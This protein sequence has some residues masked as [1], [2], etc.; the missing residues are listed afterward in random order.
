MAGS[1]EGV[2][3]SAAATDRDGNGLV[4]NTGVGHGW[5]EGGELYPP[6]EELYQQGL[7]VQAA[8]D[9]AEMAEAFGDAALARDARQRAKTTRA[10]AEATYWHDADGFYAFST[11]Y[12]GAPTL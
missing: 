8:R 12:P 4:E 5:V 11:A 9:V 1:A 6:H 10:A 7:F 3:R 2:A